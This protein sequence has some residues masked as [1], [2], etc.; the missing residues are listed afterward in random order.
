M[1]DASRNLTGPKGGS[2]RQCG[3]GGATGKAGKQQRHSPQRGFESWLG[4]G[5]S[6]QEVCVCAGVVLPT[7]LFRS[8]KWPWLLC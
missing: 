6:K 5:A 2:E 1:E 4:E 7:V 3:K 8:A